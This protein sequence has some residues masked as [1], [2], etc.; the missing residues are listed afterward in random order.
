[1]RVKIKIILKALWLIGIQ[2]PQPLPK[3][4][5]TNKEDVDILSCYSPEVI[6][7]AKNIWA[8]HVNNGL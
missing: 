1:L 4:N 7:R 6:I 3:A 5:V 2:E 8:V